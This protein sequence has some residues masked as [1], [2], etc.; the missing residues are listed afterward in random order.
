MTQQGLSPPRNPRLVFV[1]AIMF[2]GGLAI[3]F[4]TKST[5]IQTY[6]EAEQRSKSFDQQIQN[7]WQAQDKAKAVCIASKLPVGAAVRVVVDGISHEFVCR[8]SR[9]L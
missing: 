4:A 3:Q 5:W 1:V 9:P 6:I 8:N 7:F 2:F